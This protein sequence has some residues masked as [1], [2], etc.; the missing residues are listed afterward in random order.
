MS[1]SINQVRDQI[2]DKIWHQV[3]DKAK[4]QVWDQVSGEFLD[5]V[6]DKVFWRQILTEM[7][8]TAR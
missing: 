3:R 4:Y 7:E 2:R 6:S 1:T 5:Q 8:K